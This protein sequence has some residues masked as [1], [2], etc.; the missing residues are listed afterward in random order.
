MIKRLALVGAATPLQTLCGQ[1]S[2]QCTEPLLMRPFRNLERRSQPL[3]SL[4]P[5]LC[6]GF[7]S[8]RLPLSFALFF[9]APLEVLD[10]NFIFIIAIFVGVFVAAIELCYAILEETSYS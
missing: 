9:L 6:L 5:W 10:N 4:S 2:R 8:S 1:Q 3:L 7:S